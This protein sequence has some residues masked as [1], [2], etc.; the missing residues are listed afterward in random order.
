MD[1]K[2]K[3]SSRSSVDDVKT[4]EDNE[5]KENPLNRFGF[6]ALTEKEKN[7][8]AIQLDRE[9]LASKAATATSKQTKQRSSTAS[10]GAHNN[11][12]IT[13]DK[14]RKSSR[15]SSLKR[16]ESED[17]EI[18]IN[19]RKSSRT[20]A[21]SEIAYVEADSD[22]EYAQKAFILPDSGSKDRSLKTKM[23]K[24][25][26]KK[27]I[28]SSKAVNGNLENDQESDKESEK[29]HCGD[30]SDSDIEVKSDIDENNSDS[31]NGESDDNDEIDYKIQHILT[32]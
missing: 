23:S 4:E 32:R 5:E 12:K 16:E 28:K 3:R 14:K 6:S 27:I 24:K 13:V 17:E 26:V 15:K 7:D 19:Q 1:E 9:I 31:D 25:G 8:Q 21:N 20:R 30:F 18:D 11:R 22:D 2:I 10:R 29:S